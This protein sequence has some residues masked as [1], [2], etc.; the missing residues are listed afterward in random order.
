[1]SIFQAPVAVVNKIDKIR[2]N[3]LWGSVGGSRKMA[4]IKWNL[5]CLPKNKGGAGTSN[6]RDMSVVWKGIVEN[7]K[8]SL[9]AK[10][11]GN[12]SFRWEIG[13]GNKCLFWE[14]LWCGV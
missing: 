4:R 2:R 10:W 11:M 7:T 13:K 3:F 1:M 9:V 14:D 6:T 8:D 12:D 5:I